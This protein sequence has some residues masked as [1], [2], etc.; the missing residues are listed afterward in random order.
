MRNAPTSYGIGERIAGVPRV[1]HPTNGTLVGTEP[2]EVPFVRLP[3]VL[4]ARQQPVPAEL[5]DGTGA[6]TMA[7]GW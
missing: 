2:T 4:G 5:Q 3:H 1:D 7:R 6:L